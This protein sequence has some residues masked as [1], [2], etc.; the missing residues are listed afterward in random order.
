MRDGEC[1]LLIKVTESG[2]SL[3]AA[4][5]N[6]AEADR[7]SKTVNGVLHDFPLSSIRPL[8]FESVLHNRVDT[9]AL[10]K[11]DRLWNSPGSLCKLPDST[12]ASVWSKIKKC[13]ACRGLDRPIWDSG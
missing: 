8:R 4:G 3:S 13:Q 2:S 12:S 9:V 10:Q 5:L 1:W 11:E 7:C 6:A